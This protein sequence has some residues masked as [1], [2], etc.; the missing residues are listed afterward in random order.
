MNR[1]FNKEY[2]QECSYFVCLGHG[3]SNDAVIV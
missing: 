3:E 1:P 2:T